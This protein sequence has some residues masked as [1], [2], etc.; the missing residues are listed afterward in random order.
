MQSVDIVPAHWLPT[1]WEHPRLIPLG[2]SH[3]LRPIRASDVDLDVRA[4]RS[5]RE[6]LWSIYGLAWNWPPLRLD[7]EQV[8]ADL[9]RHAS[10][11]EAHESFTYALFDSDELGLLGHVYIDPPMKA[12]ADAEISWW[13]VDE[14]V[15]SDLEARLNS[16]VPSWVASDWPLESPRYVGHDMPWDVWLDLPELLI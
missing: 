12:G 8:A 7:R 3:H 6:R 14:L 2:S 9:A 4:V 10:E 1:G 13:I 15:G 5:S 11:T 16:F